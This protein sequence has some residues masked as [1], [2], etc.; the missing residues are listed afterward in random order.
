MITTS[1]TEASLIPIGINEASVR[2]FQMCSSALKCR[3]VWTLQKVQFIEATGAKNLG[4]QS[5]KPDIFVMQHAVGYY[6]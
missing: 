2:L 5:I 6:C 4:Q 3:H 1:R